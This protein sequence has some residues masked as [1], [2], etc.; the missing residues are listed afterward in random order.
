MKLNEEQDGVTFEQNA[1]DFALEPAGGGVGMPS[2]KK[3]AE[4]GDI[5]KALQA[6]IDPGRIVEV[7]NE[8]LSATKLVKSGEGTEEV[9]DYPTRLAAAIMLRDTIDGKPVQ[10]SVSIRKAAILT[11]K[12]RDFAKKSPAFRQAVVRMVGGAEGEAVAAAGVSGLPAAGGAGGKKS[13]KRMSEEEAK[14]RLLAS[15]AYHRIAARRVLRG[16]LPEVAAGAEDLP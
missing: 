4:S 6:G 15:G 8:C 14:R 11:G 3:V 2:V 9:P 1:A 13:S 10:R 12:A 5:V 7:I 16:G